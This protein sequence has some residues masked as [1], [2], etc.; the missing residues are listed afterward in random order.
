MP[1]HGSDRNVDEDFLKRV[2]APRYLFTGNGEHGNPERETFRMLAEARPDAEMELFLTYTVAEIDPGAQARS[3]IRNAGRSSR[4]RA[5]ASSR[6]AKSPRPEWSDS[7]HAL[8]SLVAA[9]PPN[10]RVVEPT[11]PI[12]EL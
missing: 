7:D 12:V 2:T 11:G 5:R 3:T 6:P 1:H 4:G 9:L 10:I 8:A